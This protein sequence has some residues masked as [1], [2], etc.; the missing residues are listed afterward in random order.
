MTA[1]PEQLARG[2]LPHTCRVCPFARGGLPNRPVRGEGTTGPAW[3]IVGEGPGGTETRVGRPFCGPSGRIVE[4]M[5]R[6]VGADRGNLWL[7]NATLCQPPPSA[8]DAQ[9]RQAAECCRP[10]LL[11]ELAAYPTCP[12]LVLGAVAAQALLER[13]IKITEVAG[14]Y[15]ELAD[16]RAVIPTI[17]PAAILRGGAGE[18]AG[19]HSPDLMFW[20]LIYDAQKVRALGAGRDIRFREDVL[21]VVDDSALAERIVAAIVGAA[22]VLKK[23]TIDLETYT[24]DDHDALEA[25][26]AKIRCVGLATPHAGAAIMWDSM[27]PRA[28]RLLRSV[29]ADSTIET[30]AHNSLYDVPVLAWNGFTVAGPREDTLLMHHNAFPGLAHGLQRVGTQYF[31]V[32]PWKADFRRGEDTPAKLTAYCARDALMTARLVAP[33]Q[34]AIKRSQAERTYEIDKKMALAAE[35]MHMAGVPVDREVNA[36]LARHFSRIV[37]QARDEIEVK[38]ND[39]AIHA[40]ILDR[41]AFEQAKRVRGGTGDKSGRNRT[42]KL[43]DPTDFLLRHGVR[44]QELREEVKAG[45]FSWQ[46]NATDHVVAYLKA[47]GVPMHKITE[48]GKTATD[49]TVLEALAYLPEVRSLIDYRVNQKL[50]STF[51]LKLPWYMD[52]RGRTHPMWAVNAVTGRWRS[53]RPQCQNWGKGEPR[54]AAGAK[55]KDFA[56]WVSNG[57]VGVP[58]LRWQVV[59]PKGCVFVGFDFSALEARIIALVSGDRFLLNIFAEGKDIHN[60]FSKVLWPG[61][62]N[63]PPAERKE[64]RD[65]TKRVSYGA[66]YGA[67]V[68]TLFDNIRK[69]KPSV[70]RTDIAKA[71]EI[72]NKQLVGVVAWHRAIMQTATTAGE[73]RSAILGRRCVFPLGNAELNT[74]Y[75]FPIQSTAADIMN[76]GLAHFMAAKPKTARPILQIHDALVV[77]CSEDV[78]EQTKAAMLAS[79]EQEHTIDGVTVRFPID[80]KVGRSWAEV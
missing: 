58:N 67:T 32:S 48:K 33:L 49:K 13:E 6:A 56:A 76:L 52:A 71:H 9:K 63:L 11:S 26:H 21:T 37:A 5:I 54:F 62:E 45:N 29:L 64:L 46:I 24:E 31:A 44:L 22:R 7:T 51:V 75:N 10:R 61:W 28:I 80:L 72:V 1:P 19:A 8:T 43:P 34:I 79:F 20:N 42:N 18:S 16:G 36:Q 3:I 23:I 2:P 60:E 40:A 38:A 15:F 59:A 78:V 53:D 4:K 77:E 68:E 66:Y 69:D 70:R 25:P 74:V 14:A 65:L 39:P 41:L 35:E 30:V 12:V 27:P 73:I 17:H 55:T 57:A 47:R 50:L